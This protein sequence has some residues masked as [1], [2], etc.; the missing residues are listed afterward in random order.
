MK[1]RTDTAQS[2]SAVTKH[3]GWIE[4]SIGVPP[5]AQEALSA[6]LF[7]LGCKGLVL[8]EKEKPFLRA[9]LPFTPRLHEERARI[10]AFLRKLGDFFPD[11]G[12]PSI[13][14]SKIKDE[15]WSH[16]WKRYFRVERIT[17]RLTVVPA[18]E[19]A[20]QDS[21]GVVIRMD[22]GPAFGT[23]QHP[24]TRM[25]LQAIE[26]SAMRA[27]WSLLDVG[28]GSGILAIYAVKLG[29]ARVLAIDTDPDALRWA[30]RN[31]E[32]NDASGLIELSSGP[33]GKWSGVFSLIVA[34]LTRDALLE[35][36]PDFQGLLEKD[37]TLILSGLLQ[38]QVQEVKRPLELLGF[39]RSQVATEAEWACITV[40]KSGEME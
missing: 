19:P 7:D 29:A 25:C 10:E 36:L 22:P 16:T 26:T 34:N 5:V 21:G 15:D 6:F 13:H 14:F 30:R 35:L 39:H 28:T 32:L 1:K 17:E 4:I 3:P 12:R 23:G 8:G 2:P 9:Y 27:P 24:T 11:I 37:G 38:E 33:L 31:I 18:W 40:R 20:P